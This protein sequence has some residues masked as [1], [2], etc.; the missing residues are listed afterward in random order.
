M[1]DEY[2]IVRSPELKDEELPDIHYHNDIDQPAIDTSQLVAGSVTHIGLSG[3]TSDQH[4]AK[5][6]ASA[7][8]AGGSDPFTGANILLSNEVDTT[9]WA[10]NVIADADSTRDLGS[11]ARSWAN[12]YIDNITNVAGGAVVINEAGGDVDFRVEGDTNINLLFTDASTDRVGVGTAIPS[13]LLHVAGNA[14]FDGTIQTT[15]LISGYKTADE[16]VISSTTLQNDDHLTVSLAASAKYWFKFWIFTNN[17]GALGGFKAALGGTV[18]V[19][20]LK[21]QIEITDDTTNAT[22]ALARVTALSS[23][24]GAGLGSGDNFTTIEGTI[25]TS[26]AGTFL[27]QWAQNTSEAS[28]TTVQRNSI[29]LGVRIG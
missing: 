11:T 5:L 7:H 2:K 22:A 17:A 12:L 27:L 19:T 24:V 1:A 20:S 15:T 28:N 23:A 13:A 16:S 8:L 26:T 9:G 10:K 29:L 14:V 21:A 25:E 6:H 3:V 4:H 18:G